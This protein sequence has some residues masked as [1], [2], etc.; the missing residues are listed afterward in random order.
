MRNYLILLVIIFGFSFSLVGQ[1]QSIPDSVNLSVDTVS[2]SRD[3][4]VV[5]ADSLALAVDTIPEPIVFSPESASEYL[6]NLLAKSNLW[7]EGD[8]T[9]RL[10]VERL[11][12]HFVEPFDSVSNRLK[13]FQYDSVKVSRG[14]VY[15]SDTLPLRWLGP[16]SFIVDTIGLDK[17]PFVKEITIVKRIKDTSSYPQADS[18]AFMLSDIQSM[19]QPYDT[20]VR[21]YVD[22]S[23]LEAKRVRIHQLTDRGVVPSIIQPRSGKTYRFSPDSSTV[24]L[25]EIIPVYKANEESPFNIVPSLG[26]PDSLRYAVEKLLAYTYQ[27]D[28]FLLHINDLAGRKTSL[29]LSTGKD[30]LVRYW[31]RNSKNDSITIWIGNPSKSNI[32]LILEEDVN[33]E[34]LER[35][36]IDDIPF[37]TTRAKRTLAALNPL[38]EIPIYWNSD[39]SS[40]FSLSQNF[41]SPYWA[42]GGESSLNSMLDI[43]GKTEYNNKEAKTRWTS[44]GRLRYGTTWTEEHGFRTNTDIVE[45][46]SQYNKVMRERLDFSSSIYGKTQVA[47]GFNYPNNEDIVSKFLNPGTFTIGVGFEYKPEK[48]TTVNI[49]PL[50]YRNTFVLDTVTINQVNHGIDPDKRVRHEMGGQLV[51]RNKLNIL[52]DMSI[53]NAV[54]LFTNYLDKPKNVDVDWEFS[55]EKQISMYFKIRLNLHFIYDDDIHFTI[56]DK[57]GE[58]ILLPDGSEKKGPRAQFNQLL[59]LTLSLKI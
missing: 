17:D 23:Y 4:L 34:R 38:K 55:L 57:A 18:V 29:W 41:L 20:I 40:S 14:R 32:S 30:D 15:K 26:M 49:S 22:T 27:R 43:N 53:N 56:L 35:K 54:R 44:T 8:D 7:R 50:S 33:V 13:R 58:P 51:F 1:A 42:R 47:K 2:V 24:I 39:F 9:M 45:I 25:T 6:S 28:S 37:T 36:M 21:T 59:G 31:V 19:L 46:N 5:T 11:V 48:N 3:S 16:T 10:S 12:H 52:K